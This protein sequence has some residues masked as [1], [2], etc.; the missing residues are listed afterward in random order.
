MQRPVD[1]MCSLLCAGGRSLGCGD[2]RDGRQVGRAFFTDI[3][4]LFFSL[5]EPF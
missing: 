5:W 2:R 3:K 1:R 4:S